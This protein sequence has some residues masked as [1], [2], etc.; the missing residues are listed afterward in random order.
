MVI[1]E[2]C[3]IKLRMYRDTNFKTIT[4]LKVHKSQ[5]EFMETSNASALEEYINLRSQ[6]I[7]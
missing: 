5:S 1:V 4:E 3:M 7:V 2:R 6:G